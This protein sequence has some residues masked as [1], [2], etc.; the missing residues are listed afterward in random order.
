M[1]GLILPSVVG[2]LLNEVTSS[3][4][5]P[6]TSVTSKLTD[7][8][9]EVLEL[10]ARGLT[11]EEIAR[12]LFLSEGTVRNHIGSIVSKPGVSDRTRADFLALQ[13]GLGSD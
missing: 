4:R 7:R 12:K 1:P 13:H 8:E 10:L 2:R 5:N 9:V 6:T 3:K 11:N